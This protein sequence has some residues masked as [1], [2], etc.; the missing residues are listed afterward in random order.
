LPQEK[1][2][3]KQGRC[4]EASATPTMTVPCRDYCDTF[5]EKRGKDFVC[6]TVLGI[7]PTM[8]RTHTNLQVYK[9][10]KKKMHKYGQY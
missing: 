8:W 3:H 10:E 7:H 6:T 4:Q 1:L 2:M 9:P 5:F